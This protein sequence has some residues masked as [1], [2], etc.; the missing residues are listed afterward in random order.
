MEEAFTYVEKYFEGTLSEGELDFFQQKIAQDPDWKAAFEMEK[1]LMAGIE[2]EG[3]ENLRQRLQTIHQEEI[4]EKTPARTVTLVNWRGWVA[5]AL[6]AGVAIALWW[7]WPVG[8]ATADG[9]YQQYASFEYSFTEKGDNS[10]LLVA[11]E[12]Q[13]EA[14]AFDSALDYVDQYLATAPNDRA[15][16]LAKG[17][18]LL[19]NGQNPA[20]IAQLQQL[21][22]TSDLYQ[23]EARWYLALALLKNNQ[24]AASLEQLEQI[25]T[26]SNRYEKAQALAQALTSLLA[27]DR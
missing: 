13:I 8:N 17:M 11:A 9:L 26:Q 27:A 14:K 25:P 23:T 10:S 22:T 19:Q 16:Q 24:I 1:H 7:L 4:I 12:Q 20:A 3:N 21:N 5:A 2:A 18:L 15:I 6:I